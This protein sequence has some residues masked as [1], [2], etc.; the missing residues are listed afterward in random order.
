[1]TININNIINNESRPN[2]FSSVATVDPNTIT[3]DPNPIYEYSTASALTNHTHSEYISL[4]AF[5]EFRDEMYERINSLEKKCDELTQMVL[6]LQAEKTNRKQ[7]KKD[8]EVNI[9]EFLL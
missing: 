1:M 4:S 9:N 2:D 3:A 7:R 5:Y 6:C 8:E